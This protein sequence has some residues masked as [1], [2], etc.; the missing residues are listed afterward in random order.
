MTMHDVHRRD[1]LKAGAA[2]GA[3]G[4]GVTLAD[5]LLAPA[6]GEAV[7][8]AGQ[9]ATKIVKN[10]CHQCPARCGIDVYVTDGR[11]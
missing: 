8:Q 4:V 3:V 1:L 9:P 11:V 5:P 6:S 7:A 2:A 10:V